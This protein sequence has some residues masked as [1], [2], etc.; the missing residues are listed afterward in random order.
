MPDRLKLLLL[1]PHLGTGGAEQVTSQL[2]RHLDNSRFN[3]QLCSFTK[4][5][6]DLQ[7]IPATV[8]L[9]RF[10][11]KR[12][13][14][15][16]FQLI[17][18]IRSE[19]PEV[20][21]SNM[22]HL[23]FLVLLLKPFLP[24]GTRILVRQNTT[25]SASAKTWIA[26]LPYRLLYPRADGIICQSQAMASDLTLNFGLLGSVMSVQANP[27][28]I[29]SIRAA[30][31]SNQS[32]WPP[33]S[34]P[35][36]LYV[37]RLA[38]EK[39]IDLLLQALYLIRPHFPRLHLQILGSGSE[40]SELRTLTGKLSLE[41]SVNFCGHR[42]DLPSFYAESTLFVLPSRYEGMPNALLE[43]AV[44]GLPIVTTPSSSGLC[45]LLKDAQGTWVS[46]AVS[47]ESLAEILLT[48]LDTLPCLPAAQRRFEHAFLAPFDT[49]TAIV[50]YADLIERV[51][52]PV[53][54]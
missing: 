47:A 44:T 23:N 48:A 14:D 26:R 34:W 1:I 5:T 49:S 46:S 32:V 10:H 4:D 40:D 54:T 8:H 43:A 3:I 36:L 29:A 42:L 2:A 39:G 35:R 7:P 37:G 12:V 45:D 22:A 52:S 6:S 33:N 28:D 17:R 21:L 41:P 9:H 20:I 51:A 50:K 18:F 38:R 27:V 30:C 24:K 53:E 13:R 25:A 19:R 31:T 11:C 15:G 16:W